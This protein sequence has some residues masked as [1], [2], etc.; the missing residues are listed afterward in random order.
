MRAW[1]AELESGLKVFGGVAAGGV[2]LA[3][4]GGFYLA[5]RN[6]AHKRA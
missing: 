1:Q 2:L 5:G 6:S 3:V 4:I